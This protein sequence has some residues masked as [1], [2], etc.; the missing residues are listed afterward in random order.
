MGAMRELVL[1][2][3][4]TLAGS[5]C[6][7]PS[8][9]SAVRP[10]S[11][12]RTIHRGPPGGDGTARGQIEARG[13][14][15]WQVAQGGVS[16][17][18]GE[19]DL[20]LAAPARA[21]GA[22]FRVRYEPGGRLDDV[23]VLLQRAG[24]FDKVVDGLNRRV[25]MPRSVLVHLGPCATANAFYEPRTS[26]IIVCYEFAAQIA[27]VLSAQIH[28]EQALARAVLGTTFF[29]FFHELGHALR[30]QL[31][32]AVVG[33]EE[34]AVD[35][36]ATLVLLSAGDMGLRATLASANWFLMSS[37]RRESAL[38]YWD[39]HSLDRQRFFSIICLAYGSD[40]ERL[41]ALK[42]SLPKQ[43]G[44]RCRDEYMRVSS[45]WNRLLAPHVRG[46]GTSLLS[47][48]EAAD[49]LSKPVE[50]ASCQRVAD[51]M[52]ALAGD[53][54]RGPLAAE[55]EP[56]LE[57]ELLLLRLS[58]IDRCHEEAWNHQRR[59]CVMAALTEDES[60]RCIRREKR[61]ERP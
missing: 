49:S 25:R 36:L 46:R 53:A 38:A 31:D 37:A 55:S 30:H 35:Q 22:G 57:S 12:F 28:G 27:R 45:A 47:G 4:A 19:R 2:A 9:P 52:A 21:R 13:P 3:V 50:E 17:Q 29:A 16:A 40:P 58:L 56:T 1:A 41:S 6:V 60:R 61:R 18:T 14:T 8:R 39:A 48:L 23:R 34:D 24:W 26:R 44:R 11:R 33:R 32:L 42:A 10:V 20:H 7:L 51:R 43:R 54:R 5:A 15:W 59:L